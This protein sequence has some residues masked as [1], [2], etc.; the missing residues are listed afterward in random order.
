MS[1]PTFLKWVHGSWFVSVL[2]YLTRHLCWS[3]WF[4]SSLFL[5][6]IL[7]LLCPCSRLPEPIR[8]ESCEVIRTLQAACY[9][10]SEQTLPFF[11]IAKITD[12]LTGQLVHEKK[13]YKD[14]IFDQVHHAMQPCS[15]CGKLVAVEVKEATGEIISSGRLAFHNL[16]MIRSRER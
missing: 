15:V 16:P 1:D 13:T 3:V 7:R 9:Y 5:H 4:L 11:I 14:G 8:R 12:Y 10:A 2:C 6:S